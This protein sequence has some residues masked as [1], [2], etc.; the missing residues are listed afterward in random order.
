MNRW[1][2]ALL[3]LLLGCAPVTASEEA[4]AGFLLRRSR[5][6]WIRLPGNRLLGPGWRRPFGKP[7]Q[8][9]IIAVLSARRAYAHVGPIPGALL[10]TRSH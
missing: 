6:F 9:D 8:P 7:P 1:R 10:K 2:C 3:S 5:P 4:P